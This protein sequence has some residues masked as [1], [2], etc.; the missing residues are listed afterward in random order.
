MSDSN[1]VEAKVPSAVT[2]QE[3][4]LEAVIKSKDEELA[5]VQAERDN[6]RRGLLKAKG[7]M[8]EAKDA[9]DL[10]PQNIDEIIERKVSEKVLATREAQILAEKNAAFAQVLKRNKEL[11]VALK[12]RAQVASPSAAGSNQAEPSVNTSYFSA[13]QIASLKKRGFNDEMVKKAEENARRSAGNP[14]P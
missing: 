11:E 12:N 8:P 4:D 13:D 9:D 1:T 6:Y 5:K 3:V 2:E 14:R 10:D 7:K